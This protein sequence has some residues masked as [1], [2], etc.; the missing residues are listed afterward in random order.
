MIK[1]GT[2]VNSFCLD[3]YL[4]VKNLFISYTVKLKSVVKSFKLWVLI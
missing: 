4:I 1:S 3:P 2:L